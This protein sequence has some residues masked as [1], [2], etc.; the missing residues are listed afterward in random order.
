M[1]KEKFLEKFLK[2]PV[3]EYPNAVSNK[4][5]VSVCVQ[6]YNHENYIGRCLEGILSQKT[7]FDFEILLGEDNSNDATREI[8]IEY[9]K[10]N[11]EKIKLFLHSREN[12]IR[13]YDMPTGK[14]NFTYNAYNAKG[15]YLA[16]CE[17]DDFW[18]DNSKLQKQVDF[19]EENDDYG[20]VFSDIT[21]IDENNDELRNVVFHEK[22]KKLYKSGHI[23]WDLLKGNFINTLTICA[24]KRIIL[25]YLNNFPFEEFSYDYR[26][27]LHVA[28]YSQI[29]YF[30]EITAHYRVHSQGISRISNFFNKR[31]PLVM[32]SALYNYLQAHKGNKETLN[33]EV[34]VDTVFKIIT[35][36]HLSINEKRPILKLIRTHPKYVLPLV[37]YTLKKGLKKF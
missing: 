14:F 21:M 3:E 32:Q 25:E 8:C 37:T 27:W 24:R 13:V 7:N 20:L 5:M 11:P 33:T 9:A 18:V 34:I 6:T 15:K 35:N 26:I 23:F 29:K 4:P 2:V 30:D 22:I 1:S 31:T 12:N 19:L 16:L 36:K 10:K 17:G 28:T